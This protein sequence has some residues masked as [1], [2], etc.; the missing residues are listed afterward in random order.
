VGAK[1]QLKTNYVVGTPPVPYRAGEI[2]AISAST[3]SS[4]RRSTGDV[5]RNVL[6]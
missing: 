5:E 2:F 1:K 6:L 4:R 3:F